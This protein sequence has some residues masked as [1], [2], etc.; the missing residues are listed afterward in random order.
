MQK[1]VYLLARNDGQSA[2][3]LNRNLLS[4]LPAQLTAAGCAHFS[5]NLFDETVAAAKPLRMQNQQPTIDAVVFGWL[6]KEGIDQEVERILMQVATI[7][8]GYLL[9]EH[10]PIT[11]PEGQQ[12]SGGMRTPGMLQLAFLKVPERLD[13]DQWLMRWRE[14]HTQVAIDTQ[15]TYIYRQNVVQSCLTKNDLGYAAIVEEAFPAEAMT[16]QHAFYAAK[17]DAQLQE[18]QALM[19]NS[20]K[21][22]ID[23]PDLDVLPTSEYCW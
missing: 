14:Q 20:S 5:I 7:L 13:Y 19:W 12:G 3:Q 1:F 16:S 22:F 17:S 8:T 23:L 18:R 21:R 9:E 11:A 10:S 4:E 2:A 6:E 15:S